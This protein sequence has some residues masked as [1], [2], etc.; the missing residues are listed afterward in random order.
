M[1]HKLLG[2]LFLLFSTTL[3]SQTTKSYSGNFNSQN[4]KGTSNYNYLEKSEER[5]FD[6]SFNFKSLD[7]KVT[8]SGLYDNNQKNGCL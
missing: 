5:I 8:I 6:G 4:F 2:S 7:N 3:F 1:K